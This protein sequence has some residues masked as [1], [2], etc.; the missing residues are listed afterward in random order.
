[1]ELST[2]VNIMVFSKVQTVTNFYIKIDKK[3]NNIY[4]LRKSCLVYEVYI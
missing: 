4:T 2:L 1:M 3:L